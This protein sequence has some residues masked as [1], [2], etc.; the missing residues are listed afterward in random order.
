MLEGADLEPEILRDAAEH[1][2]LVLSVGV[3]VDES[4]AGEDLGEGFEFEVAARAG[5]APADVEVDRGA[6]LP[7]HGYFHALGVLR[8]V[9]VQ[10]GAESCPPVGPGVCVLLGRDESVADKGLDAHAC[11]GI[12]SRVARAGALDVL[13]ERE[14]DA[15][16]GSC[17]VHVVRRGDAPADLLDDVLPADRVGRP[18]QRVDD[19][20]A[21]GQLAVPVDRVGVRGVLHSDFGGDGLC[22]LVGAG[23]PRAG[24]R[25]GVDE[26]G[27]DVPARG[28]DDSCVF[29][30][31]ERARLVQRADGPDEAAFDVDLAALDDARRAAGPDRGVCDEDRVLRGGFEH[32]VW[33]ERVA[34]VFGDVG[35][36]VG[37]GFVLGIVRLSPAELCNAAPPFVGGECCG[38]RVALDRCSDGYFAAHA[39]LRAVECERDL[40]AAD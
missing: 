31:G 6:A 9:V 26:A 35:V 28:V 11:A 38:E 8:G 2:D 10:R 32:H 21:A 39:H 4:L 3:A 17:Q 33:A 24:V 36:L 34:E 40:A 13:A 19:R 5:D 20:R 12:A 27:R 16:D 22:A 25:V 37:I 18:V 7:D 29:G 1:E 23:G 30:D 14:L 15:G